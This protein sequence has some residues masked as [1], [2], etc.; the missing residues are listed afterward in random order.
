MKLNIITWNI[1]FIHDNWLER[2]D[3][4]NKILEKEIDKTDIIALQEATLPFN[5]KIKEL[6]TFLKKSN[7]NY[8]DTSLL[9][10]NG[11][12]KYILENC[13]KYNKYIFSAFEY[14]MNKLMWLCGYIFSYWG[15]YIKKLY[16]KHPYIFLS[17][18]LCCIPIFLGMWYFIGLLTIVS[19]K[20]NTVVQS[21]YIGNRVIQYFDFKYN[22]KDIRCI[23]IHFP[24]GNKEKDKIR[25]LNHIK[26]IVTFCNSKD[27]VI[28]LGD[29]NDT[30]KSKMYK[31]LKKSGYKN[32]VYKAVGEELKTF[33]SN[34]PE[35]CIDFV[36]IK[37]DIKV[38]NASVFGSI[39]A[40][41][42]KGI[43]VTLDI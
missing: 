39:N 19:N 36:M 6:H 37:G 12:Y 23:N 4:I 13:P 7:V 11:L 8:F 3:H 9:E 2:L 18:A 25:R 26:E 28:I 16:F 20:I 17:I 43:K 34:K 42:H 5:N 32:A 31:Y 35:K 21:K 15:E 30:R 38:K 10:R 41:D 40:S 22:N 24:P 33:P 14:L 27:N 29:F 1:N